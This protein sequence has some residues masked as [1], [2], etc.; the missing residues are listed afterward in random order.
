MFEWLAQSD[1][2]QS[3]DAVVQELGETAA[4]TPVTG[5]V[6]LGVGWSIKAAMA[7]RV[8][9]VTSRPRR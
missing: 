4:S 6:M 3:I 5:W 7:A 2:L 9:P 1:G 8:R